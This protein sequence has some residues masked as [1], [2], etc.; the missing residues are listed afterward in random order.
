MPIDSTLNRRKLLRAMATAA[1]LAATPAS[2]WASFDSDAGAGARARPMLD[3]LCD[4]VIPDTDTPGAVAAGVP[5]FV[6]LAIAHGLRGAVG[7]LL[8]IF[9]SDLERLA[10]S[11]PLGLA[12][13]ER[14][15]L[16]ADVDRRTMSRPPDTTLSPGLRHWP[17]LKTLILIG[18]YTSE[19]G[20][21]QELRY[22]LVPGRLD[23]D[24]PLE[25]GDRAW[26]SDW[27]AV[28]YG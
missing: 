28:K 15:A 23:P 3:W 27:T 26:S 24:V 19:I 10:G 4:A 22:Q 17:T 16:L 5:A 21:T 18:Y 25:P 7:N 14:L 12:E 8:S 20:S 6:D 9:A 13:N 2:V 1:G 11:D